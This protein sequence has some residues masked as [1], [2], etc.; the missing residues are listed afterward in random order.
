MSTKNHL[1]IAHK[2]IH[3]EK[4]AQLTG[5][6]AAIFALTPGR[7][8]HLF[9]SGAGEGWVASWDLTNPENGQLV[10]QIE[11]NIFALHYI[12]D[13][14]LLVAG[15]MNGGVHWID[16]NDPAK[17]KNIAHHKKGVFKV[18][19]YKDA[20][21]T[22]G[23]SGMLTKWSKKE[24]RAVESLQLSAKSLRS[25]ILDAENQLLVVGSSDA[26]IYW[27]DPEGMGVRH[28]IPNA[29]NNSVFALGMVQST[30]QVASGS[31][32]AHLTIWDRQ[33]PAKKQKT[34]PAHLF[35]I[36]DIAFH[37]EAPLMATAS[38]DKTIKIWDTQNFKLLKVLDFEK[39]KGH[40]NSVNKL[41]WST[42][43]NHLIS[44]SD[45]RSIIIWKITNE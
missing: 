6:R 36:N 28:F 40:L 39:Y 37:P 12:A 5:H 8:P 15:N 9:Y 33:L 14:H 35:T 43:K 25:L 24:R 21:F 1:F 7:E 22:A 29:H 44:A 2:T 32:D 13:Q 20:I 4:I 23:G 11:T 10:A 42:Y 31:R 17:T 41:L 26:S 38:R 19:E 16:L 3:I 45:D 34:I 27:V 18:L 30:R